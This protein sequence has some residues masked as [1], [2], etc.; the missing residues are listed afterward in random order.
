MRLFEIESP[1]TTVCLF[2]GMHTEEGNQGNSSLEQ[3][4][5]QVGGKL[6]EGQ[7]SSEAAAYYRQR[8]GTRLIVVGYSLGAEG[9][10]DMQAQKPVLS[11]TIAG[12][13]TTLERMSVQGSWYNFYNPQELNRIMRSPKVNANR[14]YNPGPGNNIQVKSSHGGIVHDVANQVVSLILG[15]G[16]AAPVPSAPISRADKLAIYARESQR[17]GKNL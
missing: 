2:K 4:A 13:P 15:Q 12:Y 8:P 10:R 6:F 16:S 5:Q 14:D 1:G 3:I 9:V 11:I 17:R 7:K